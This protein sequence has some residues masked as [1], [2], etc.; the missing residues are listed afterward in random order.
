MSDLC[1]THH[2]SKSIVPSTTIGQI[3]E[4]Q[5]NRV[6]LP[7]GLVVRI[8]AFHA[9]GPGSIPGVGTHILYHTIIAMSYF[10]H[11]LLYIFIK[12][13]HIAICPVTPITFD[14]YSISDPIHYRISLTYCLDVENKVANSHIVFIPWYIIMQICLLQKYVCV[15]RESNPGRLLGR[16][17]C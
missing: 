4:K 7:Y 13:N 3:F 2:E 8:P 12:S 11:I 17:P 10:Q 9:G 5:C 16:Q 15:G 14:V 1:C 6:V